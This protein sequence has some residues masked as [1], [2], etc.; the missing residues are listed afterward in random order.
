MVKGPI[1]L[2]SDIRIETECCYKS[3]SKPIF[4]EGCQ[5][6]KKYVHKEKL[7]QIIHRYFLHGKIEFHKY[8]KQFRNLALAPIFYLLR[9]RQVKIQGQTTQPLSRKRCNFSFETASFEFHLA[10]YRNCSNTNDF[11]ACTS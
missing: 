3:K 8:G 10:S 7:G 2:F 4:Y 6:W 11:A 9:N 5:C 1:K